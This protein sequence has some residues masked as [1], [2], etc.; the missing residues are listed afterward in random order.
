MI[1]ASTER[2]FPKDI[3][4]INIKKIMKKKIKKGSTHLLPQVEV[5]KA[6]VKRLTDVNWV[7]KD[8]DL[9]GFRDLISTSFLR[10]LVF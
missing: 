1:R 4:K 8:P 2:H 3:K 10:K 6:T 5:P 7:L 9:R